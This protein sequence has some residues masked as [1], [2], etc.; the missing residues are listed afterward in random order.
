LLAARLSGAKLI[1]HE[2]NA[3]PGA[4][5]RLLAPLAR[6]LAT[7]MPLSQRL[8]LAPAAQMVGNPIRRDIIKGADP[9]EGR[10]FFRLSNDRLV[11]LVLSGSQG[12]VGINRIILDVLRRINEPKSAASHWQILWATGPN[13]FEAMTQATEA[14]GINPEEHLLNPYIDRMALAYAAADLVVARAGALTLAELTA[15]GRPAVLVPLPT[16]A[17]NHQALNA[18][19]LAQAGAAAIIEENDPQA[20]AK[21]EKML[22]KWAEDPQSLRAIGDAALAQGRPEAAKEFARIVLDVVFNRT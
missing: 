5:N 20:P 13:H 6:A 10:S 12:A 16:A 18:Q 11:C 21:L 7:A 4:A 14:M 22:E 3:H 19:K 17:G 8:L 1:L 2:Q 15:L 9:R